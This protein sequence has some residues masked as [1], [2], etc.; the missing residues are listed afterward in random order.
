MSEAP[1]ICELRSPNFS[2]LGNIILMFTAR[3][4]LARLLFSSRTTSPGFRPSFVSAAL[5]NLRSPCSPF[6]FSKHTSR[7]MSAIAAAHNLP[8]GLATIDLS[9]YDPEQSKL[10]EERCILVDAQDI[11]YGAGDKKTCTRANNSLVEGQMLTGLQ[12]T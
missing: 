6:P 1:D 4:E 7:T 5:Y 9:A 8:P 11:A 2:V 10:M 3:T 12:A